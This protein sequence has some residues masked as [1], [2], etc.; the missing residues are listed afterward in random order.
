MTPQQ[1][2]AD[3]DRRLAHISGAAWTKRQ[4]SDVSLLS[5]QIGLVLCFPHRRGPG[6]LSD[7]ERSWIRL[8][9]R[10]ALDIEA[11]RVAA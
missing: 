2:L 7:I 6:G 8:H 10:A 11:G 4:T 5:D 3:I 9:W 1:Q